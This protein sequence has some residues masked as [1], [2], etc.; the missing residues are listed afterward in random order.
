MAWQWIKR[1][2]AYLSDQPWPPVRYQPILYLFLFGAAVR[3]W[4]NQQTPPAFDQIIADGTYNV[5]LGIGM[6][7]PVLSLISWWMIVKR[8]GITRYIGMWARAG[9]DLLIFIYLLSFHIVTVKTFDHNEPRIFSRYVVGA[10]T[11]FVLTLIIRDV[12]TLV[13]TERLA[14]RLHRGDRDG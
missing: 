7:A 4:R 6:G 14:R 3:L 1:A 5:W 2:N 10:T 9:A 12:W 8:S 13:I 11:V